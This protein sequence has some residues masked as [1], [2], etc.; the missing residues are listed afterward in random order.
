MARKSERMPVGA[1]A[2][3]R[4]ARY[5]GSPAERDAK[6]QE[7]ASAGDWKRAAE[8]AWQPLYPSDLRAA[9][10]WDRRRVSKEMLAALKQDG[11]GS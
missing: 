8:I 7:A 11:A 3:R 4:P 6:Y 5:I 9:P 2:A 10:W 1:L